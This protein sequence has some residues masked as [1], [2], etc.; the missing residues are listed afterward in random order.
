M[1]TKIYLDRVATVT[2]MA[3]VVN[4]PESNLQTV[5]GELTKLPGSSPVAVGVSYPNVSGA[6]Q[7]ILTQIRC[8][9]IIAIIL[10]MCGGGNR[11]ETKSANKNYRFGR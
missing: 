6:V 1:F 11:R 9:C 10:C 2:N 5:L 4:D 3:N 7:H 8:L